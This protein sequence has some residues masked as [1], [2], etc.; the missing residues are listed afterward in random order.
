MRVSP[1]AIIDPKAD[2]AS[3]VEIGPF[4]VI[5]PHVTIG[6][7]C[8]LQNGVTVTGHT[9]LGRD[10]VLHPYCVF[11][12]PPQ[13]RKYKGQPTRLEIGNNNIFRE[14]VTVH[15]GTEKGG[16]VTRVG[17][18]NMLMVNSHLGHDVQMGSN[19]I[20]AN[21][22]MIAGHVIIGD[23]VAMMGGVGVHHFARIGK[24]CFIGGYARIHHDAPPF[25][26][27]DGADEM[28]GLNVKGLRGGGF[29]DTD[30]DALEEA[31]NKLFSRKNETPF[32][33]VLESFDTQNGLN[34][35]VKHMVEFLRERDTGRHGR[36]Q[37][38]LR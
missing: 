20:L 7:G 29:A 1:H 11:G 2:I 21:N 3:D 26:K 38:R 8:R 5:G 25:C 23:N 16:G 36:F 37:Q 31:Y 30:I 32:A 33:N 18:N 14:H 15:I 27:L 19:C 6:A 28:R 13:D 9:T 12:G 35:H 34:P 10:N 4:C 24:F 22:C 17:N